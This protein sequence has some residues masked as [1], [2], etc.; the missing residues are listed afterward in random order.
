[1]FLSL[2]LLCALGE[3]GTPRELT[4]ATMNT[5]KHRI[6][7]YA[8]KNDCLPDS[9]EQLPVIENRDK[10]VKDGWGRPIRWTVEADKVTLISYG[11]DGKPGGEE[12]DADMVG[13]FVTKNATGNWEEEGGNWLRHPFGYG[14]LQPPKQ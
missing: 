14:S 10:N 8:R 5:I 6:L 9:P 4:N 1:M 2:L 11:R 12:E 3:R 13:V 7:R